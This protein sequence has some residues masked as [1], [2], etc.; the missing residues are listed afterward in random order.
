[1]GY[2]I[3]TILKQDHSN[4]S[5]TGI[6]LKLERM[7]HIGSRQHWS[8]AEERRAPNLCYEPLFKFARKGTN[9]IYKN[10]LKQVLLQPEQDEMGQVVQP[11]LA[12][13]LLDTTGT[14]YSIEKHQLVT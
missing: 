14:F 11:D 6:H 8:T 1:M 9:A 13:I 12:S 7:S 10:A 5:R 3:I 2:A 4:S